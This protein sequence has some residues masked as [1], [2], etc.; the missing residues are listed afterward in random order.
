[1]TIRELIQNVYK[2]HRKT[3]LGAGPM[4]TNVIDAIIEE[5][6]SRNCSVALIPSRRQIEA[7]ELGGGYVNKWSTEDFVKYVRERD[8]RKLVLLSRDHSG[9]WQYKEVDRNGVALSH[10]EAMRESK[11]SLETDIRQGF[12][13]LH[14]DPSKGFNYG[15]S[16]EEVEAD[17]VELVSFCVS[18]KGFRA[19]FEVGADEQS[20]QPDVVS[21]AEEKLKRILKILGKLKLPMPVFYV[22]QTGTKVQELRNVGSFDSKFPVRGML[23][24]SVQLPEIIRMCERNEV[25]LKEHNADYLSQRALDWHKRFGIHATNVAPEFG[26]VET[27]AILDLAKSIGDSEFI[28]YFSNLVLTGG[29]WQKWMVPDSLASDDEKVIIA[30]HYHFAE[31]EFLQQKERLLVNL[32][33]RGLDFN[34]YV[35]GKIRESL[36]KYLDAFG[37]VK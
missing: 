4:S 26:T 37:H 36:A 18:V 19:E 7:A 14:I 29:K 21:I 16:E 9:P 6:N 5:A 13:M 23:P 12:D 17:I 20:H 3:L 22:L 25:F 10:S 1:M 11:F 33:K 30:G 24:P 8:K 31:N 32:N 34:S 27:R 28:D 35:V 15:R 2:P